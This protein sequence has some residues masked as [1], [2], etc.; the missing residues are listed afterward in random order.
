MIATVAEEIF[1]PDGYRAMEDNLGTSRG[2]MSAL[3]Y[4]DMVLSDLSIWLRRNCSGLGRHQSKCASDL[5]DRYR[6][7]EELAV[8]CH[9]HGGRDS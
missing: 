8:R 7:L 4:R 6:V 2:R 3:A 5:L 1:P 9:R